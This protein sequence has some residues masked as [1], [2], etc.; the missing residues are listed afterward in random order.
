MA[1]KPKTASFAD[2]IRAEIPML[3]GVATTAIFFTV[4]QGW[5]EDFSHPALTAALFIWLFAVMI[6][7]AF[8]VVRHAEAL[9]DYLGEPF[10]T[11][12]LTLAVVSIEVTIMATVMLNGDPNPTLPRDTVFAVLMIVL[13]GMIGL[14]VIVGAVRYREQQYNLQGAVAFLAVISSLAVISLVLP[15]FTRSTPDSS[16]TAL[17]AVVFGVMTAALYA[18]FLVI[19]TVRHRAFFMETKAKPAAG[20]SHAGAEPGRAH[21]HGPQH[22][23]AYH[24]VLLVV[25][26]L[27]VVLLAEP[28]AKVIDYGIEKLHAPTTLGG[29]VIA[30]LIL[31][32]E[33]LTAYQAARQNQLQ[34]S[35]NLSL[36]SA[37][38]T[39][40]LTIPV[41]LALSLAVGIPLQLGLAPADAILLVLTLFI[42][43]MTFSGAPTNILLGGVHLV[44]FATFIVLIF[45]P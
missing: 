42:A 11:L 40:G 12:I 29:I 10:G 8:G 33:G 21:G 19:Q 35:V 30:I 9:A 22:S 31:S 34:R 2:D 25:T 45:N 27:P 6:W 44:L 15:T 1:T 3:A 17:Q 28:L 26:L 23:A 16:M 32:P 37:L 39:I 13:N 43:Q 18:G 20:K 5:T 24:A 38:S 4:G 41:M 14:T 7:C 36:G